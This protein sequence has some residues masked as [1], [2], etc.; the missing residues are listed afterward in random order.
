MQRCGDDA[1]LVLLDDGGGD[2][3]LN[4]GV[5]AMLQTGSGNRRLLVSKTNLGRSRARNCLAA[6]ARAEHLLLLDSDMLP[7]TPDYLDRYLTLGAADVACAFGGFTVDAGPVSAALVLHRALQSQGECPPAWRRSRQP[8]KYVFTSNLLVRRALLLQEPFDE[9]FTGWGWEDVE[10]GLRISSHVTVLHIDNPARHS[11]LDTA[12]DLLKKYEQSA[13]NFERLLNRHQT[14]AA[15]FGS[16]RAARWLKH[17][18]GLSACRR[19][20]KA[21][22]LNDDAP[23]CLRLWGIKLYKAALY[24]PVV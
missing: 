13:D 24:A 20:L 5:A 6:S 14:A 3:A 12:A 17:A 18:P 16:Y 4:A 2:E 7:L 9:A 15:A 11:G 1:E 10:W 21:V 22:V 8:A 23:L 19:L